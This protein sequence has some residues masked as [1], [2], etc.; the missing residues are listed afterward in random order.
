MGWRNA[1]ST[2]WRRGGT[3]NQSGSGTARSKSYEEKRRARSQT[4]AA[5]DETKPRD[6]LPVSPKIQQGR[7]L[8]CEQTDIVTLNT[9][10]AANFQHL[11]ASDA[12]VRNESAKRPLGD[13]VAKDS[14]RNRYI[15]YFQRR[16]SQLNARATRRQR[17]QL[18][19]TQFPK[20]VIDI[21]CKEPKGAE[22]LDIPTANVVIERKSHTTP[23]L[24]VMN[25][26]HSTSTT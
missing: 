6:Q 18:Q 22:K 17:Q 25:G 14:Q 20:K 12:I 1:A 5:H 15:S 11:R 16:T 24:N 3:A 23:T 2:A 21:E 4:N 7:T 19:W 13:A 26:S 10:E 9:T 8:T